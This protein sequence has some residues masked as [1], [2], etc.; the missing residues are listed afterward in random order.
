MKPEPKCAVTSE[1][2]G[3]M[4]RVL[5]AAGIE[6]IEIPRITTADGEVISASRVRSLLAE[7]ITGKT[8]LNLVPETTYRFLISESAIPIIKGLQQRKG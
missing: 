7:G 4:H 3:I 1:Y 2:N 5:P 6:M 8:L